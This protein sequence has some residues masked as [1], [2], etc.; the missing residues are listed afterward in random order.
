VGQAV[1]DHGVP[2]QDKKH[3]QDGAG[4]GNAQPGQESSLHEGK[5]KEFFHGND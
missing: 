1:A 4:Y 5:R 2:A 3:P